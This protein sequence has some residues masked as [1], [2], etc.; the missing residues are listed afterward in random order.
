MFYYKQWR[1]GYLHLHMKN[2]KHA[3]SS[4]SSLLQKWSLNQHLTSTLKLSTKT[5]SIKTTAPSRDRLVNVTPNPVLP[6][7]KYLKYRSNKQQCFWDPWFPAVHR[8]TLR[9]PAEPKRLK[10]E[11]RK[12]R[13]RRRRRRK[14][15]EV[16]PSFRRSSTTFRPLSPTSTLVFFWF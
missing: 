12:E 4:V 15:R 14:K 2:T 10:W 16:L 1:V 11:Q 6:Y 3:L 8:P 9:P 13:R 5:L 7:N